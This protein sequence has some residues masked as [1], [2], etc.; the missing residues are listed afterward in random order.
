MNGAEKVSYYKLDIVYPKNLETF[1]T[2]CIFAA[3]NTKQ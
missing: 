2:K 3:S 1:A